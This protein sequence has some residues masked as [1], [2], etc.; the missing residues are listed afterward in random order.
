MPVRSYV[1]SLE[2]RLEKMEKLL[3]KVRFPI[4]C[5]PVPIVR[6]ND[7]TPWTRFIFPC[8]RMSSCAAVPER[9]LHEGARRQL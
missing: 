6:N 2:T 8:A 5:P 7:V 9:G 3:N 4:P 1:E